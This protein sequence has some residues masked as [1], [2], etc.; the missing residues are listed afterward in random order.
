MKNKKTKIFSLV[1]IAISI[2]AVI[3]S[4]YFIDGP[5]KILQTVRQAKVPYLVLAAFL[6]FLFWFFGSLSLNSLLKVLG[7]GLRPIDA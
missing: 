1:V 6:M 3:L 5:E 4:A 7:A 2:V